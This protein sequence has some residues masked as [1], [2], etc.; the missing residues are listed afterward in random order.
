MEEASVGG[1]ERHCMTGGAIKATVGK[2]QLQ[3]VTVSTKKSNSPHN[4]LTSYL[5][6]LKMFTVGH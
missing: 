2:W 5:S 4:S 3:E 1:I 6:N